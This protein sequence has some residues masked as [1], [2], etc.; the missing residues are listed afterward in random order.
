MSAEAKLAL[1]GLPPV[2][3]PLTSVAWSGDG[4][5]LAVAGETDDVQLFD[6]TEGASPKS[7]SEWK[8]T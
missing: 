1:Q 4:C 6:L 8:Q 2:T 7:T 3:V 5:T